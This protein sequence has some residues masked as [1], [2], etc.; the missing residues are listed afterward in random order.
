MLKVN[1][2]RMGEAVNLDATIASGQ[3]FAFVPH[4]GGYIG[5]SAGKAV[6]AIERENGLA[7]CCAPGDEAFWRRYFDLDRDYPAL[8]APHLDDPYLAACAR[9]FAGMKLLRQ[10]VWETMCAFIL[11]ANNHQ[12]RIEGLYR[13]I[14]ARLGEPLE[15]A[16]ER[17]FAFPSPEALARAKEADLRALGTGYRAPYLLATAKMVADGFSLH[18]DAMEY[19]QALAHLQRLK[20]VGEKVA[21]CVLLFSSGH[22]RAFPVD[23]WMERVLKERYGM[24]GTRAALKRAAQSRFG[25][26]AGLVQ[27]YLFHGARTGIAL[28]SEM[29]VQA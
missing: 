6:H 3:T 17:L 13:G 26:C 11:S 27:Q 16:G 20:G 2:E 15:W 14:A 1:E 23:V 29:D 28:L 21:D 5:V 25:E 10:P 24:A 12:K 4:Q 18:L 8:L 9:A 19:E 7:L 22:G